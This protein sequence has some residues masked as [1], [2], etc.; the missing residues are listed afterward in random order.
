MKAI[1]LIL[2][3]T[4]NLFIFNIIQ[5]SSTAFVPV[6]ISKTSLTEKKLALVGISKKIN[7]IRSIDFASSQYDI[8]PEFIIAL[9][10]TESSFNENAISSKGYKGLM[11]IPQR[12]PPDANILIGSRIFREKMSLVSNDIEKAICLYKGYKIGSKDG[13]KQAKKVINLYNTIKE[14]I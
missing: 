10:L 6:T 3:V 1:R 11:Q 5:I 7:L 2:F 13:I 4:L 12:V 14:G 9:T 8:S